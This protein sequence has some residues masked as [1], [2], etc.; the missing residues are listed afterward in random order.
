M[1][2]IAKKNA[3]YAALE[4][5]ENG[6]TLGIGTG[7]TARHFINGLEEKI[8][9][10]WELYGIPTSEETR[11]LS[12]N[13]GVNILEPD[14]T[15]RIDLAVDGADEV[16]PAY[17]LIKGGGGALLREKII[18][19][20]AKKFIVIADKTKRV[21]H[22]GAFPLPI[23]IEPFCWALTIQAVRKCFADAGLDCQKCSLRSIAGNPFKSDGDHLILD[24]HLGAI[25]DPHDLEK[26]LG[27]IPG[28]IETGLFC[29]MADIVIFGDDEGVKTEFAPARL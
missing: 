6:M 27:E 24:C 26:S 20:A 14:E 9:S 12:I 21:S 16:D 17:N 15:T 1:S 10:G 7:S 4:H 11:E 2:D 25:D 8:K 22:L 28:V 29:D 5:V 19:R 13:A 3:G 18:A 23:E